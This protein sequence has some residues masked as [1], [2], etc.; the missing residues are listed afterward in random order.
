MAAIEDPSAE[1]V[2]HLEGELRRHPADRYPVQHATACFHLGSVHLAADRP[3]QAEQPLRIAARLFAAMPVEHAKALNMLG[4]ALRAL[5]DTHGAI[6]AFSEAGRLFTDGGQHLEAAAATFNR[7]LVEVDAGHPEP[8]I[9]AFD[10]ARQLFTD[11]RAAAQAAAAGRELGA[12]LLATGELETAIEALEEAMSQAERA[13]DLACLGAAANVAGLAHLG[14]GRAAAAAAAFRTAAGTHPRGVRAEGH[15]MAKANLALALEALGDGPR[16]RLAARQGR[17]TPGAP[18]AVRDQARAVLAR[19]PGGDDDLATVL[20]DEPVE[21]W[22][23]VV[24]EEVVRWVD[25]PTQEQRAAAV[26]LVDAHLERSDRTVELA[27]AWLDVLLELPPTAMELVV[28]RIVD[29]LGEQAEP[30]RAGFR[31]AVARAM[32]HFHAPQLLRVRDVF[33]RTAGRL[34]Q[35]GSWS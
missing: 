23:A 13:G 11:A 6:E 16:A 2:L 8:A 25:A 3:S 17:D 27:V 24:R 19:L 29:A 1:V 12:A 21:R 31:S 34:G 35:E 33:E 30:D 26:A 10:Q 28:E 18:A 15:A 9:T 4:V 22:A 32:A 5:G 7:G 14:L 20:D